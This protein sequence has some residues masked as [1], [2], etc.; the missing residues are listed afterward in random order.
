[1]NSIDHVVTNGNGGLANSNN[2]SDLSSSLGSVSSIATGPGGASAGPGSSNSQV[3]ACGVRVF[4]RARLHVS[5]G[6]AWG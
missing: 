3:S 4:R 5:R 1:M 6:V 2:S